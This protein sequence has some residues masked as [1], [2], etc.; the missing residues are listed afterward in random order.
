[1]SLSDQSL[2]VVRRHRC[3]RCCKLFTFSSSSPEPLG[4]LQPNLAQIILGWRGFKFIQMK[5]SALFQ[6]EIITKLRKYIDKFL[7]SSSPEPL[8]QFQPNLAQ[9]ILGW[10][11][12]KVVQMER[13]HLFTLGDNNKIAKVHPWNL[14]I[15]SYWTTGPIL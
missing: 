14:K 13:P 5:G 10:R 8:S 4:Q 15:S 11:G 1:M 6:G 12:F 9:I 7:K 3:C 2:S